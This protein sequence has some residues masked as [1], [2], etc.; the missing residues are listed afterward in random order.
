MPAAT[1]PTARNISPDGGPEVTADGQKPGTQK[2]AP[3]TA[4]SRVASRVEARAGGCIMDG[5]YRGRE[6]SSIGR[7]ASAKRPPNSGL[8]GRLSR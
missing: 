5:A 2:E 3:D 4:G 7:A 8:G 6:A 1:R